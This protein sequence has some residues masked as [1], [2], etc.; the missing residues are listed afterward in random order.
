MS[1]YEVKTES[2]NKCVNEI[3]TKQ[4]TTENK[5]KKN[6]ITGRREIQIFLHFIYLSFERQRMKG[7][8]N[9][10]KKTNLSIGKVNNIKTIHNSYESLGAR[11]NNFT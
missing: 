4:K 6:K 2:I 3:K 9:R 7:P 11:M 10:R 1:T 5:T 8:K